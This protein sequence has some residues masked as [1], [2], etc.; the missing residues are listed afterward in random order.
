MQ[1]AGSGKPALGQASHAGPTDPTRLTASR[2]GALPQA[3]YLVAEERQRRAVARHREVAVVPGHNRAQPA[4]HGRDLV[5][6]PQ[7]QLGLQR[8]HLDP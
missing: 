8:L 4:T 3:Q 1:D 2:E 5:M 7:P 6:Q